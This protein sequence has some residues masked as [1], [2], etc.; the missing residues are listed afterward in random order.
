MSNTRH[1]FCQNFKFYDR[2]CRILNSNP[3]YLFI[4]IH[5]ESIMEQKT[6]D[7][8][9]EEDLLPN[10]EDNSDLE[11]TIQK[12]RQLLSERSHESVSTESNASNS[13]ISNGINLSVEEKSTIFNIKVDILDQHQV[14]DDQLVE[15]ENNIRF[16][17][18]FDKQ[19][20]Y[21]DDV[22]LITQRQII[23]QWSNVIEFEGKLRNAESKIFDYGNDSTFLTEKSNQVRL[24]LDKK[25]VEIFRNVNFLM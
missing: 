6:S 18:S 22:N 3:V 16:S 7:D 25:K 10:Y 9:E 11:S 20:Y 15:N 1:S 5:R 13:I 2:F 21:G 14:E 23:K 12:L 8:K 24:C 19:E 17:I 4:C